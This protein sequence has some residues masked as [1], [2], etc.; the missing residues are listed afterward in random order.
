MCRIR[1]PSTFDFG[2]VAN[3]C[4]TSRMRTDMFP[5]PPV[6]TMLV[7]LAVI[8]LTVTVQ[9]YLRTE[10][11]LTPAR[12]TWLRVAL[13]FAGIGTILVLLQAVWS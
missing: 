11:K 6:A 10:G 5:P 12:H 9:D 3:G 2:F 8:F 1:R 13:I 7:A 4:S